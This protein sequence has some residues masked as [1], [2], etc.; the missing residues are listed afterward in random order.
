MRWTGGIAHDLRHAVRS[1]LRMP[2]LTA[3][4]TLSLGVGIGVNTTVFS[5]LEALVLNPL[6]GVPGGSDFRL[7]E[8]RTESGSHPGM[9]WP[10]FQDLRTIPAFQALLA[11]RMVPLNLGATGGN[12]RSYGMLV[13]A[14]YFSALGLRPALGRFF[15]PDE[16]LRSGEAPVVVISDEYWRAHLA[17]AR[18]ILGRT[19]RVNDRPLTIV[20]VA[21]PKFQGTITGIDIA[22][23]APATLAPVLFNGST[24]LT[25]RASRGYSVIGKLAGGAD[26]TRARQELGQA[27]E[28]LATAY[29]S[30][31]AGVSG[32]ILA[33]SNAPRGPQR[34]MV[35]AIV[36][37]QAI[38]LLLLLAVCGNT[39]NLLLAR[40]GA[41]RREIGVRLALGS[42][43]WR[44]CRLLLLENLALGLLG[45]GLGTALAVWGTQALRA[46]PLIGAFPIRFQTGIDAT[47]LGFAILLGLGCGV[48]FGSA[49]ALQLVRLNP[50]DELR[51]GTNTAARP[52]L[53]N[54]LMGVEVA[55]ATI[56]LMAAGVFFQRFRDARET[57]PGFRREGVLL[58]AYDLTGGVFDSV[59]V[60]SFTERL[61]DRLRALPA[62]EGAAIAVSVPL[63]IH[64][65]PSR[66][67][68]LEGRAAADASPDEALSNVVTP[69][70]FGVMGLPLLA[71][72]DFVT[73]GD[74]SAE[75]QVI[76]NEAFVRRYLEGRE[77]LGRWLQAGR[78]R[79]R[80]AG[81]V[82][83]SISDA[84]G[85]PPTPAMY[86]SYR[87]RM[88]W[89]GEI[90]VRSRP[91]EEQALAPEIRRIVRE[92]DPALP[93][94][95]VRTLN[96]HVDRNLFLQRIPARM[97]VVLGPLIL[98][99][100]ALG[101]YAVVAYAVVQRT[102]EIGVRLALGASVPRIVGQLISESMQI[103]VFGTVAG[104]LLAFLV[105]RRLS[106]SGSLPGPVLIGV[107]VV[108]LAVALVSCW[109]P[110]RRAARI[111]ALAALRW[112]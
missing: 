60:R 105:G 7:I 52:G 107:P 62:G 104:V 70:Y 109:L 17:G 40:A 16:G 45:A 24:E 102:R 108:T 37:L 91:G 47:G 5:W 103:I 46:V 31:N 27:M 74:R 18:G 71:G 44:I 86:F 66:S 42:S 77:P 87:D 90:H 41:R 69:G 2:V 76:V 89:R 9:S 56:V 111:D 30:T 39:A 12:E 29:P 26:E 21:P 54:A 63:D 96:E 94:Y 88:P 106:A 68:V 81:V 79:Y 72:T 25:E 8:T 110:A 82:K 73:L 43:R 6:P 83:T 11:A 98:A 34:F 55:L 97:F 101:I 35:R 58:A 19:L 99:L 95:D 49:P 57:D 84:F 80:I 3:V 100:A 14:N 15:T 50:Q 48:L 32:E 112:E 64:G 22:L 92:L 38:M 28:R 20:G 36:L 85:E 51:S 67:F 78:A 61:L 10:E 75:P 93:I 4:V 1:L 13:S 65:L 53:R 23:W 59:A 33:F